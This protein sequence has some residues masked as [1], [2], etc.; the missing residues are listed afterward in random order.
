MT[1]P[2]ADFYH[3]NTLDTGQLLAR[4]GYD[5]WQGNADIYPIDP[6]VTGTGDLSKRSGHYWSQFL[7][8][9][10]DWL[11]DRVESEGEFLISFDVIQST[12]KLIEYEGAWGFRNL[13]TTTAHHWVWVEGDY[14]F[15]RVAVA[16]DVI[17]DITDC[18]AVWTE[19]LTL[20]DTGSAY[21]LLSTKTKDNGIQTRDVT[22]TSNTHHLFEYDLDPDGG[23]LAFLTPLHNQAG[24]VARVFFGGSSTMESPHFT[25]PVWA[26]MAAFDNLEFHVFRSF[27]GI[28]VPAGTQFFLDNLLI[29]SPILDNDNWIAPATA[30]AKEYMA[31]FDTCPSPASAG[32]TVVFDME[33]GDPV[34]EILIGGNGQGTV[35]TMRNT[36]VANNCSASLRWRYT[37]PG[38]VGGDYPEIRMLIPS[39][40]RDWTDA[41]ELSVWMY[42]DF[43]GT[44][45]GWTLQPAVVASG[46]DTPLGNWNSDPAGVPA[47]VWTEHRWDLSAIGDLSD[48]SLLRFWYHDGDGWEPLAIAGNVDIYLDDIFA[49]IPAGVAAWELY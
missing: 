37:L 12:G 33:S 6:T 29:T 44:K 34:T 31:L 38:S 5:V 43:S 19:F 25:K 9:A 13:F 8:T 14:H 15:H 36:D 49:A 35:T 42:F 26:D 30:K 27:P 1:Q 20:N 21:A 17:N 48:V 41:S 4:I 11:T 7:M 32:D 23:W 3:I 45:T 47:G 16:M 40:R 28:T 18:R 24:S 46:V 10:Q 2:Y 39:D 22:G